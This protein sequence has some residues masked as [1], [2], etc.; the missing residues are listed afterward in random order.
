[1]VTSAPSITNIEWELIS[2]QDLFIPGLLPPT[3]PEPI[4]FFLKEKNSEFNKNSKK[5]IKTRGAS[6]GASGSPD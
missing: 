5:R 2:G 1:M 6:E 4:D 3:P